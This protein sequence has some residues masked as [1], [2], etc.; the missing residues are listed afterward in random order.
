M[1][2]LVP[3]ADT[4]AR[5]WLVLSLR[6]VVGAVFIYASVDK[7][8]HPDRFAEIVWDFDMLPDGL[9]NPFAACLPWIE[10]VMGV[11]LI[12]GLWVPSAA[13]ISLGMTVM[14]MM[15]V[16]HALAQGAEDF[17]CGCFSTIQEGPEEAWGIMWRD[18]VLLAG[19]VW[20]FLATFASSQARSGS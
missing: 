5:R 15:A 6:L 9:V 16:G 11:S 20:L 18:A 10:L 17:H 1:R 13:I 14:F 8:V 3:W 7:I 19:T 12:A 4:R 2:A